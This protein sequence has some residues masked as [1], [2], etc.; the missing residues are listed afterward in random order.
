[1]TLHGYK[2]PLFLTAIFLASSCTEIIEIELDST[3][4]RLVVHGIITS[5]SLNHGVELTTTADYFF[6]ENPPPVQ[7]ATVSVAFNDTIIYL[8]EIATRP[9][10]YKAPHPFRGEPGVTYFLE[11]SNV[12]IDE[13]GNTEYYTA[14]ST[15]PEIAPADSITLTRFVTPFFSS[16]QVALWSPDPPDVNYYNYKIFLNGA[17]INR[18]L[19]DYTVQPDEFFNN[20][21]VA[22]LPVG[23]LNDDDEDEAI[24]P[25][26]IITLEINSIPEAYYNF[27]IDAQSEIFGNNPL[28]SGPPANVPTNITNNAVGIF[29]AYSIDRVSTVLTIPEF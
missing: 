17:P 14:E 24:T 10:I 6:N 25:G 3:Y 22:G 13:D 2:I 23:F 27:I 19:S 16:Y 12:D 21:Y 4:K 29:A 11:I 1:M 9:G 5:D 15:M 20:N 26:D 8:E 28:F 7:N 18:R